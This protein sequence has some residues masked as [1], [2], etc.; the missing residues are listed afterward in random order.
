MTTTPTLAAQLAR[1]F[2]NLIDSLRASLDGYPE[3]AQLWVTPGGVRNSA[4]NLILHLCGNLRTFV[5][6]TLGGIAYDRDRPFE[7][8]GRNVPRETLRGHIAETKAAVA[9]TLAAIT[10][11]QLAST[12][13]LELGGHTVNTQQFVVH[14]LAHLGYHV[15]QLDYHRRIV[16]GQTDSTGA[17]AISAIAD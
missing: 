11:D 12:F 14:L 3:E 1:S 17:L 16:T 10:P 2:D 13:P 4:G 9:R 8:E 7:F 5:G 15:G 6:A